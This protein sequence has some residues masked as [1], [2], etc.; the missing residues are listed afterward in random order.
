M[1]VKRLGNLALE[2]FKTLNNLNPEYIKEIFC[3]TA[4]SPHRP[5]NLE[6][7]E[8]LISGT[9]FQIKLKKKLTT[10]SSRNVLTFV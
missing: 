10:L 4:F 8:V 2:I 7:N 3:K 6:V 1:E 9:P 5:L